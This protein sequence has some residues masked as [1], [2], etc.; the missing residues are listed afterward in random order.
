MKRLKGAIRSPAAASVLLG[1]AVF[2][3]IVIAREN[4]LLQPTEILAYDKFVAMRAGK[5]VT[6]SRVAIV[7]IT[8]KDIGKY[9]FPVPDDLLARLLETIARA[10][11]V[12]IG[13]DIYRDAAVPR[14]KSRVAELN[15]VLKQYPNIVGIFGF[16]DIDH[17]IKIPFAPALAETPERYGFNDFPFEFGS[18]R[19]AFLLVWDKENNIYPS[20]SLVLAMQAGV[21]PEQ[22]ESGMRIGKANFPRFQRHEGGYVHA[23]DGGHQFLL[24]FKS[25]RKFV[26]HSLD[27][28]LS[29]RVSDETWRGKI[30][31]IGEGAESAHDFENTPLQVNMPGVELHGQAV[32]QLLRASEHGDKVTTSWNEPV[33][34]AWIFAW[35][36]LGGVIGFFLRKPVFLLAACC[37]SAAALATICWIAFTRDFWLPFVPALGGN[38]FA[39]AVIAG[40]T[41]YLDRKDRETLMRLFSQ[42]VSRTIAESMWE[43]REQFMDGNRPRPQKLSATVLFTDL[44]NFS[45]VSEQLEA[46]QVMEWMNECMEALAHHIEDHNGFINKYMG[47]AIMAVFGYPMV[48]TDEAAIRKDAFNAVQCAIEMGNELRRLNEIWKQRMDANVQMRVGIYSGPAV[49]GCIGST[50][51]LEFTVMGNTVNTAARLESFDK[52]YASDEVCRILVGHTTFDLL[53][54]QFATEFVRTIELKGK[55]QKTTIYRILGSNL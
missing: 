17:P 38:L 3:L 1:L 7:E 11:P 53:D 9:D 13:L 52:D 51:R 27:D 24:D 41:R 16:G 44:R 15:R 49:A 14:D 31:L 23:A 37:A 6:D 45:T 46:P 39:T 20:F 48:S 40:Y 19:R 5:E 34:I 4:A 2:V 12:A 8:E 32:N 33:E 55:E 25:P 50:D 54:G 47:D 29:N 43:H 21:T 18:V 28:V 42:H 35:C 26:T 22:T 36:L 30:V 10:Q